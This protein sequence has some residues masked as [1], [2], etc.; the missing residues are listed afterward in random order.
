MTAAGVFT[1]PCSFCMD[2]SVLFFSD[3]VGMCKSRWATRAAC[4][5]FLLEMTYVSQMLTMDEHGRHEDL[6]GSDR[7][8]V[9]T[10]IYEEN[11]CIAQA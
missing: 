10:Y 2:E 3:I 7:Q 8:R 9:T 11:C 6:C 1:S 4:C 5:G